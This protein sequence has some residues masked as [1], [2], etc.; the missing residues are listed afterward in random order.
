M[1]AEENDSLR[2]IWRIILIV[3]RGEYNIQCYDNIMI[4]C[5]TLFLHSCL[6]Q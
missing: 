3:G 2:R 4:R 5:M 6:R 1:G